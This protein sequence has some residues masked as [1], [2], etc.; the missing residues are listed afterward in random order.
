MKPLT[1]KQQ[2]LL[3]YVERRLRNNSPPSHREIAQHFGLAQNA[4]YQLIRYLKKKGYL[5]NSGGHRGLRLSK[6]Y[7][8]STQQNKG[9]PIVGRVAAGEPI[10]AQ[11]HIEGYAEANELFGQTDDTFI[12][13]VAGDSMVD[14]GI[15]DGDFVIVK[16]T[17]EIG[18]GQIGVALINDEATVKRIYIRRNKIA[19]E[20]ANKSAA[21]KT[22]YLKKDGGDVRIIGKVTACFRKM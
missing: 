2:K 13:K 20:P 8:D 12:L 15:M 3:N 14:A 10:L 16:I 5:T 17:S 7:L 22:I 4:V 9:I 21:Y 1:E 19:L 18:N 11:E 6:P